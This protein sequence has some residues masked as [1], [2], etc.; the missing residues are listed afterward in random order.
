MQAKQIIDEIKKLYFNNGKDICDE[1]I[2]EKGFYD[3]TYDTCSKKGAPPFDV[4]FKDIP[5]SWSVQNSYWVLLGGF[6]IVDNTL[7]AEIFDYRTGPPDYKITNADSVPDSVL[8]NAL[9]I[10]N[11]GLN[12]NVQK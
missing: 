5:I 4:V 1:I 3:Y 10:L 6:S 2:D 8:L 9:S 11:E 7:F 12:K